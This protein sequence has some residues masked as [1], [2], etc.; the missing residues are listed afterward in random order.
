M[1]AVQSH[2]VEVAGTQ[3]VESYLSGCTP[4]HSVHASATNVHSQGT[5]D[6]STHLSIQSMV[7]PIG[8]ST[9][10]HSSRLSPSHLSVNVGGSQSLRSSSSGTFVPLSPPRSL[11]GL[12]S[13]SRA[14]SRSPNETRLERR[15]RR[16]LARQRI[17]WAMGTGLLK[18][19]WSTFVDCSRENRALEWTALSSFYSKFE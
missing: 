1:S 4:R 11:R 12:R 2:A 6:L 7:S 13:N 15:Q 10:S 19:S 8:P 3:N 17:H 16:E 5:R 14:G 9:R 18:I